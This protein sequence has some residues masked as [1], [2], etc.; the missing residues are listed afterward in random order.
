MPYIYGWGLVALLSLEER[1]SLRQE[2]AEALA[3]V[4]NI[5]LDLVRV[6]FPLD[7]LD[8]PEGAAD[9]SDIIYV[10]IKTGFLVG[11]PPEEAEALAVKM[12]E[13]IARLA[14][15]AIDGKYDVECVVIELNPRFKAIVGA[16]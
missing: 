1:Q 5:K 6:Y 13:T 3:D 12:C 2:L 16:L 11:K 8:Q 7:G 14:H 9:G 15:E 4:M 10:E